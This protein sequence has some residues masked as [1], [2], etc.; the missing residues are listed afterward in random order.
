[1]QQIIVGIIVSMVGMIYIGNGIIDELNRRMQIPIG[2]KLVT[3]TYNYTNK[4]G[5]I[6]TFKFLTLVDAYTISQDDAILDKGKT[7]EIKKD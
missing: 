4:D 3:T 7:T 1:M 5:V 6:S 2:K